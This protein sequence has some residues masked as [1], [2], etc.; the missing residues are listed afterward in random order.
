M[1]NSTN[2]VCNKCLSPNNN[3]NEVLEAINEK[4]GAIIYQL[5][6][7]IVKEL[8]DSSGYRVL[9]ITTTTG[10]VYNHPENVTGDTWTGTVTFKGGHSMRE[11]IYT[12][13]DGNQIQSILIKPEKGEV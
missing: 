8:N 3:L 12:V 4:L 2:T 10:E 7:P 6:P 13:I 1:I 9:S 11:G 5:N